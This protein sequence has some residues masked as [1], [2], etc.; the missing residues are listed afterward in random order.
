[1]PDKRIRLTLVFPAFFFRH[2]ASS[3]SV[4]ASFQAVPVRD[5]A[6]QMRS[7]SRLEDGLISNVT[8]ITNSP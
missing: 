5:E 7:R 1:M 8:F 2:L 3:A 4:A 6:I